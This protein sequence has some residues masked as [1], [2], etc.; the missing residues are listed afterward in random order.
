M[1]NNVFYKDFEGES[2]L[3]FVSNEDKLIIWNG[4]FETILDSLIDSGVDKKGMLKEYFN[5]EGWYDDSPWLLRDTKLALEQLRS[6][7]ITK[8]RE[9]TMTNNLSNV[10]STIIMF[11]EK[12]IL[13]DVYI[14]YD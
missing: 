4:Y 11:L 5:H 12:H 3:S 10:I 8:V 14:E 6:F 7:D 13:D 9:T 1:I 2:E